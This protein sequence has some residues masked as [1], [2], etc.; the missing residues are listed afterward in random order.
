MEVY[1][2]LYREHHRRSDEAL[3]QG[4]EQPTMGEIVDEAL[5]RLL[6]PP[7]EQRD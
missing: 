5:R 4:T 1:Q 2:A 3:A 6:T 7:T